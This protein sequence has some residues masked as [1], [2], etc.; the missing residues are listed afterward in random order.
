MGTIGLMVI[1]EVYTIVYVIV[2]AVGLVHLLPLL[3]S[4]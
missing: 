3:E 1:F 4:G 2:Y